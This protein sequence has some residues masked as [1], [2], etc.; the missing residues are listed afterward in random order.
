M[1]DSP[2]SSRSNDRPR[3]FA[4][5]TRQSICFLKRGM[6][7]SRPRMT[8]DARIKSAQDG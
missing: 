3:V 1:T 8:A 5:K 2:T 4:L 7:G 6:R